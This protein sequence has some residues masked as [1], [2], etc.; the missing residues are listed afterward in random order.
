MLKGNVTFDK[1]TRDI[2]TR[3]N[4]SG[5][6]SSHIENIKISPSLRDILFLE[7]T[8]YQL[9]CETKLEGAPCPHCLWVCY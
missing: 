4:T 6:D 8:A 9:V 3:W 7:Y 5:L 2:H 1:R